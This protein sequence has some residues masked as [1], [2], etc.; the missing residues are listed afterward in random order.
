MFWLSVF[1]DVPDDSFEE[2]VAFWSAATGWKPS[3][4][5]GRD[6]ADRAVRLG[7]REVADHGYVVLESPGGLVLCLVAHPASR[8]AAPSRWPDLS[9]SL[10]DQVCLDVPRATYDEDAAWTVLADPAGLRYCL[11]DRSPQ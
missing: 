9:T 4:R 6:E 10:L 3:A 2:T 5:R 1:I 8:P 7:A 11:T